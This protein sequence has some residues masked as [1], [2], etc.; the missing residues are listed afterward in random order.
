MFFKLLKNDWLA[1]RRSSMW[2]QSVIQNMFLGFFALYLILQFTALGFLGGE[3]IREYFP[4]ENP[5]T[6]TNRFLIYYF[7]SDLLMRFFLQ[8][9]PSLQLQPYLTMNIKKRLLSRYLCVKSLVSFFNIA[10]LFFVI[11]FYFWTVQPELGAARGIH[12]VLMMLLLMGINHY[13]SYYID[14]NLGKSPY[15]SISLLSAVVL[16]MTLDYNGYF[17]LSSTFEPVFSYLHEHLTG[18]LI[19]VALLALLYF[20]V[21]RFLRTHAYV[22][23]GR[24]ADKERDVRDFAIFNQFGPSIGRLMQL[25]AK[26]IWRNKRSKAYLWMSLIFLLYPLLFVENGQISSNALM[27][28]S[29]LLVTGA[30]SL[31]Y[32]QLLL[33]WNSTHFDFILAQ[34]IQV[35]DYLEAKFTLLAW[36]NVVLFILSLPYG[37]FFPKMLLVNSVMFLFNTGV[38]IFAYLY[39][40]LYSSKRMDMNKGGAFSF[41]GFGAAHY[42]IM[43]PIMFM[44]IFIYLIFRFMDQRT[45]GLIVIGLVGLLGIALRRYLMNRA[46]T[47]FTERKYEIN[48]KFKQ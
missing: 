7:L 33:S 11:P 43:F 41:E 47:T 22:Q 17:S 23:V 6:V 48:S 5:V 37:I 12:W 31:N 13:L 20:L 25:E 28:I 9:Y 35:R 36:S 27:I 2:T 39:L 15:I 24:Q 32:G 3:L 42:L 18:L 34:N 38:T 40:A 10:P 29:G 4:E 16:L 8:K 46:V 44:P 19:L 1:L 14:R 21:Y 26:L 30:F 45:I